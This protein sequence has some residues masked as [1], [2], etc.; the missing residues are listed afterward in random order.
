[1]SSL[2]PS[3]VLVILFCILLIP[4][5]NCLFS[6]SRGYEIGMLRMLGMSKGKAW[7]KLLLENIIFLVAS[8]VATLII[9]LII[10]NRFTMLLLSIDTEIMGAISASFVDMS[11][12]FLFNWHVPLYVFGVAFTLTFITAGLCNTLILYNAP[13]KIM[14]NYK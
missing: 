5:L 2:L 8:F 14:R 11:V 1:M 9:T 7:R 4:L 3:A 12:S 10:N 6:T 13:L